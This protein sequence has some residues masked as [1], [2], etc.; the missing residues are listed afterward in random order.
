M[1]V[2]SLFHVLKLGTER[3]MAETENLGIKVIFSQKKK[4]FSK[5]FLNN[6]M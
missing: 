2:H 1:E 4:I 6:A 3:I 5:L